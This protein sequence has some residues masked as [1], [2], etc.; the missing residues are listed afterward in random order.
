MMVGIFA[1]GRGDLA[2]I[3]NILKGSLNVDRAD[4]R[5][6]VPEYDKDQTDLSVMP[7]EQ[8][9]SW[10][11]V[12]KVCRER[13]KIDTFFDNPIE[14][15]GFIVLHLDTAERHREDYN[16]TEPAKSSGLE[17]KQYCNQLRTNIINK[18]NEWL[19]NSYSGKIAYAVAIEETDAWVLTIYDNG[20]TDTSTHQR[21]KERLN[22]EL[23]RTLTSKQKAVL[24]AKTFEKYD[25][26][27]SDFRKKRKLAICMEKNESLKLFC[28]SLGAF[29]S[30]TGS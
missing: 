18:A 10:T 4:I 28:E 11:V 22:N 15:E 17:I 16:V 26:L 20:N 29:R 13:E 5:F 23:N 8:Y 21:P 27:S 2:V 7:E 1:E 25:Q 14:Q 3:T 24:R 19:E 6:E 9:S 12:K 30:S